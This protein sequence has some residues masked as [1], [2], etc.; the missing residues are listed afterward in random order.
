[1]KRILALL[2]ILILCGC[3]DGRIPEE[4]CQTVCGSDSGLEM[5]LEDCSRFGNAEDVTTCILSAIEVFNLCHA[6]CE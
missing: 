3:N 5:I 6:R 4:D 1:M 2:P